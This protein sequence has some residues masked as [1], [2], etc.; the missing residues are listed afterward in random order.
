VKAVFYTGAL[1]L[2]KKLI[3]VARCFKM[4]DSP[5]DFSHPTHWLILGAIWAQIA[6]ITPVFSRQAGY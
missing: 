6:P 5:T 3:L 4:A 1:A 2:V